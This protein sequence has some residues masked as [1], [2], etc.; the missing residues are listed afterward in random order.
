M[1]KI[2]LY[3]FLLFAAW[4][5]ISSQNNTTPCTAQQI[6]CANEFI[7][8]VPTGNFFSTNFNFCANLYNAPTLFY[9]VTI[10]SP[11]I[12]TFLIRPGTDLNNNGVVDSPGEIAPTDYDWAIWKN[13]DCHNITT[14]IPDR[15]SFDAPA[16][17]ITGMS[18]TEAP[19]DICETQNSGN[20]LLSGI[21]VLAGEQIIIAVNYFSQSGSPF[22]LV[23]GGIHGGGGTAGYASAH[24]DLADENGVIKNEFCVG[25]DVFLNGFG[26]I[27]NDCKIELLPA[28]GN[29]TPLAFFDNQT[30]PLNGINLTAIF[31]NFPFQLNTSYRIRLKVNGLCGCYSRELNF[32]FKCCDKSTDASFSLIGSGSPKLKGTSWM[33]GAHSW[34]VH[35]ISPGSGSIDPAKILFE[36]PTLVMETG[37][38]CYYIKHTI[39]N[40]C[41]SGCSSQRFCKFGCEEKECN[42]S[43]PEN[44]ALNGDQLTWNAIP[45]VGYIIEII[46]NGCCA[47]PGGSGPISSSQLHTFNTSTSPFQIDLNALGSIEDAGPGELLIQC[48]EVRV[49]AVCPDGGRSIAAE[50]PCVMVGGNRQSF[51][52][53][54]KKT[55]STNSTNLTLSPNP[56]TS[57]VLIEL[58]C[59]KDL[60]IDVSIVN[61]IGKLV[62]SFENIKTSEKKSSLKLNT[63]SFSKGVYLVKVLTS[64]HQI[65]TKKLIIE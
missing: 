61:N 37:G 53:A 35:N 6:F 14:T 43:S 63:E 27:T 28:P 33:H 15:L 26:A 13:A 41:G 17:Y 32:L 62:K 44:L 21:S 3:I 45:G 50:L 39:T 9:K 60:E 1:K 48:Y 46:I 25:E 65:F 59:N 10:T 38:P 29:D 36:T 54:T 52:N 57:V 56:A 40:V 64:D 5:S 47:T 23:L 20:G 22:Q 30:T 11:G 8:A 19:A 34:E 58:N 4:S 7:T 55:E 31:S 2:K 12:F 18:T 49:Y 16:P 24:Y 42:L 51:T